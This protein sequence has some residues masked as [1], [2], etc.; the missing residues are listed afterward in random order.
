MAGLRVYDATADRLVA[1]AALPSELTSGR[2]FSLLEDY[3]GN[4]WVRGDDLNDVA[5]RQGGGYRWDGQMLNAVNT[6]HTVFG[7]LR[8]E[9]I[10][11]V[12]RA[13]GTC[14]SISVRASRWRRC[15][16]HW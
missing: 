16:R 6:I 7:F 9:Q 11:W 12:L 5:L 3:E 10:V 8:E 15:R 1:P 4:L 13:N 14:A 2:L